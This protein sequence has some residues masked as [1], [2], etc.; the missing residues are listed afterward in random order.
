MSGMQSSH[1]HN[2]QDALIALQNGACVVAPTDTLYGLLARASD[3]HAVSQLY[4]L[5]GRDERKPCIVLISSVADLALF[6]VELSAQQKEFVTHV[7]PGP[8]SV[9]LP[10]PD[11]RFSYL[12]RGTRHIA[13]RLPN[14]PALVDL[15]AHVG[16]LV[17]PSANPQGMPPAFTI[18]EARHYFGHAV[19][20]YVD[21]G[22]CSG[23]PSTLVRFEQERV[24]VLREGAWKLPTVPYNHNV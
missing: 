8:V 1:Q 24:I 12:H 23:E 20:A 9:V 22:V 10:C 6:Y 5:K 19:A 18:Q 11:D 21:G 7:W 15:V 17:A 13:F 14:H 4:Q 2:W 3:Q 16:P